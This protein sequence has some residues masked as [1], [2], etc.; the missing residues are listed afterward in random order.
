MK[1]ALTVRYGY[2]EELIFAQQLGADSVVVR[3]DLGDPQDTDLSPVVYRVQVAGMQLAGVELFGMSDEFQ[4]WSNGL[5][6]AL[7][8]AQ[9]AGVETL[10]CASPI[11]QSATLTVD[12]EAVVATASATGVRVCLDSSCLLPEELAW[13]PAGD[14]QVE[15]ALG[16]APLEPGA[17]LAAEAA[18]RV[19]AGGVSSVR[20]DGGGQ[21]LGIGSLNVPACFKALATAGYDGL[22]RAGSAALLAEDDDWNPKGAANDLGYLRA[23]L[24]TLQSGG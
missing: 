18:K 22:V 4:P 20:F 8:A 14:V 19:S 15:L 6:C 21:P 24:Q 10:F 16:L 17:S 11:R 7:L 1:L 9:D 13:L 12:L 5:A 2:D 3:F 23:T